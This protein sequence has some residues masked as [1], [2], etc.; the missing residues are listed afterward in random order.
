MEFRQTEAYVER[1]PPT[2][3]EVSEL[4]NRRLWNVWGGDDQLGAINLITASNRQRALSEIE[5]GELVSLCR[6]FPK[7]ASPENPEPA[8]HLMMHNHDR[9]GGNGAAVDFIGLACHGVA[10]THLDA[11]CHVWTDSGMWNGR[12][13]Q[14]HIT[15]SGATWAD[16]STM[17]DR[18]VTRGV[19]ID[20]PQ[21]RSQAFVDEDAPVHGWELEAALKA[22]GDDLEP[23]DAVVVY[24]GREAWSRQHGPWGAKP[25]Q[26]PG[27]AMHGAPQSHAPS[28]PGL[29]VSCLEFLGQ[30][31]P[32][33]LV[34]DMMDAHPIAHQQPWGVHAALPLLGIAL[35]DNAL[36]EPLARECSTRATNAFLLTIAPLP[37]QGG[38]G[39]PV[40]PLA[41]L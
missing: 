29:H 39:S 18:L 41:L 32:S 9:G 16:V 38:T 4:L 14:Q 35:V 2:A 11:L 21:F 3:V 25:S 26:E 6:P 36:L 31:R 19:L 8:V 7:I 28:R 24:S 10:G 40:N 34:W 1:R 30:F 33:I 27:A 17:A 5:R 13:P 37:I 12:D 23:G 15:I 20:I 22:Q